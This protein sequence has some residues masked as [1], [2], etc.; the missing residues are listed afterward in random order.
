M[1]KNEKIPYFCRVV[2]QNFPFIEEDFDAL[3]TYQLISKVVEYLNKVIKSQNTLVDNVNNLSLAFQQLHDYVESYFEN[4]DVQEEINNKL[5]EMAEDG[6]LQ[7]II[8]AYIQANVAWTFDTVDDMKNATNLVNG[9]FAQTLGFHEVND[10][11]GAIY[12]I[13]DSGTANEMDVIAIGSLYANLIKPSIV[14]PEM[15]GAYGDGTH[16]DT[17]SIQECFTKNDNVQ[18]AKTYL[19]TSQLTYNGSIDGKCTGV[20]KTN[21]SSRITGAFIN[22][23]SGIKIN[24]LKFDCSSNVEFTLDDKF[25]SYNIGV[26]ANS[27]IEIDN[28]EFHNLYEKFIRITGNTVNRVNITNTLFSS[29]NKTNVYMAECVE[30]T[31]V[32]NTECIINIHGNIFKGF[33]YEY[34]GTYDNDSNINANGLMFANVNVKEINVDNNIFDHLG[35]YGSVAGNLGLS[36]LCTIDCYFN[37]KPL[38]LT[39]NKI[40]NNHWSA[41]RLHCTDNAIVKGNIFTVARDCTEPLV[42]ISDSYNSTGEASLGCDNVTISD[43]Q[44]LNENNTFEQ[45]IFVNSYTGANLTQTNQDGFY[46]HVNNLSIINN[47]IRFKCKQFFIFDYSLK[48]LNY[49]GNYSKGDFTGLAV[50]HI[51]IDQ[52]S[53]MKTAQIGK[54]FSNTILNISGNDITLNGV[55]ID[56]RTT[57]EALVSIYAL[58]NAYIDFNKLQST[59]LGYVVYTTA[60]QNSNLTNNVIK[61]NVGGVFNANKTYDNIVFYA[62][63]SAGIYNATV[64]QNNHTYTN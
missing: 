8:T 43:N 30:V 50:I 42:L 59:G 54:D 24:G 49:I 1:A 11:G 44:F 61:A 9:S 7:E 32:I 34:V 38:H 14:T 15:Y 64:D 28:C 4:L 53:V 57:D 22:S 31:S 63:S 27:D 33:E 62:A 48:T 13:T 6:T 56:L 3:T 60:G 10:G 17:L 45:G 40:I 39:N 41:L 29:D 25:N 36:R 16:D 51:S 37:V 18:M 52:R 12:K 2:L 26:I 47:D 55:N 20:I 19:I 23:T 46:G 35:R 21:P 58:L 5:D